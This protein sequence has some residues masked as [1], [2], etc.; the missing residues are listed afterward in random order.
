VVVALRPGDHVFLAEFN[1]HLSTVPTPGL[2]ASVPLSPE[3]RDRYL[4]AGEGIEPEDDE[5]SRTL[6]SL[7]QGDSSQDTSVDLIF[8]HVR[9]R[10]RHDPK[11]E[12]ADATTA[13]KEGRAGEKGTV[14]AMIALLRAAKIPSRVVTGFVLEEDEQA[15]PHHCLE[16]YRDERW[17]PYDPV[18]GYAGTLPIRYVPFRR[19]GDRV[20]EIDEATEVFSFVEISRQV[21][22][23]G[24]F[25]TGTKRIADVL[26]LTRLPVV[27]QTAIA[28]LLM[29]PFGALI[30]E[31]ARNIVGVRTYG[32]FTPT[33]LAL[34]FAFVQWFTAALIVLIGT[35]K[36]NRLADLPLFLWLKEPGTGKPKAGAT[37]PPH[38]GIPAGARDGDDG[39]VMNLDEKPRD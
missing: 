9:R 17:V 32:T 10:I 7:T 23:L 24:L 20:Y 16:A 34:A 25:G 30:T 39:T 29:L 26:D 4:T 2:A 19:G 11:I 35:Y 14:N 27:T 28:L 22:P 5:I 18:G 3:D 37:R 15:Q 38:S 1:I 8:E 6:D 33:L 13:L 21:V 36:G 12:S 31:I